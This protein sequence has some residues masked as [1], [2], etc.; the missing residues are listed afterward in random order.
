MSEIYRISKLSGI[1]DGEYNSSTFTAIKKGDTLYDMIDQNFKYEY[2]PVT[3]YEQ[4]KG[5][6]INK[7]QARIIFFR[8]ATKLT[9]QEAIKEQERIAKVLESKGEFPGYYEL[10][11]SKH[12]YKL[13][14]INM[15]QMNHNCDLY[16]GKCEQN[17][18]K[19]LT[20]QELA[21]M[22]EQHKNEVIVKLLT[23]Y[24]EYL[25]LKIKYKNLKKLEQQG[26]ININEQEENEII[27]KAVAAYQEYKDF[28][29][30]YKS[31]SREERKHTARV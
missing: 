7:M 24:Q 16:T 19:F 26:L 18:E 31:L 28:E 22:K 15:E 12:S 6:E 27:E 2:S 5:T 17:A 9:P 11:K 25:E 3:L 21:D 30:K 10:P 20:Q 29:S 23:A 8:E 1:T 14:C 13:K 4:F